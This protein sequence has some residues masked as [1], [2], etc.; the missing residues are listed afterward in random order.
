M[1]VYPLNT[2]RY[3]SAGYGKLALGSLD[4]PFD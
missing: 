1:V 2:V 3:I 4:L